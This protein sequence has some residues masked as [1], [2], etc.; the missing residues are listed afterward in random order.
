MLPALTEEGFLEDAS[1]WNPGVAEALAKRESITLTPAHWELIE[2]LRQYYDTYDSSPAMR[3][4]VKFCRLRLGDD[5]GRSIYL[6]KLF[7]GSP[8]KIASKI[9]GLPKPANCL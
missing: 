6:L 4:L 9:A 5:K 7:P 8:A 1:D 3:A 2:L